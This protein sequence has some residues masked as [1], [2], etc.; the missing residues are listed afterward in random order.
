M[1]E[2]II[3]KKYANRRIY[4]TEKSVYITL[5]R[6]TEIIREGRQVSVIDAKTSEDVTAFILS[7][8]IV[9]EAK[10]KNVLLPVPFL[11][12]V[13]RHGGVLSEFF[14]KYL[15]LTIKNYL[16]YKSTLDEQ[17]TRW[18][19]AGRNFSALAQRSFQPK[20]PWDYILEF[21]SSERLGKKDA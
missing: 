10:N 6:V 16:L 15:E 14:E 9:E 20:A 19:D 13:I 7:Q 1:E 17:F 21:F 11:H 8:I 4:D 5:E 12:L 3:L 18:L 2:K